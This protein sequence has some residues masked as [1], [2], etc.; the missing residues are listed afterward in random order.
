VDPVTGQP[1]DPDPGPVDPDGEWP[2]IGMTTQRWWTPVTQ[3]LMTGQPANDPAQ[4]SGR[5]DIIIGSDP[6]V[7]L[8]TQTHIDGQ[9]WCWLFIVDDPV[10]Q[11]LWTDDPTVLLLTL[12]WTQLLLLWTDP[13]SVI[14]GRWLVIVWLWWR[15]DEIINYWARILL[16]SPI[17]DYWQLA[18]SIDPVIIGIGVC[19]WRTF[20]IDL[21]GIIID[22]IIGIIIVSGNYWTKTDIVGDYWTDGPNYCDIIVVNP[23]DSD[24][25][26][27]IGII[28]PVGNWKCY[29]HYCE[30]SG[31]LLL[32]QLTVG[33]W[34]LQ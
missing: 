32:T 9:Y 21:I 7:V 15:R 3:L 8:K 23:I 31:Q 17:V 18:S 27:P 22:S 5:T 28:D 33:Q 14:D 10:A 34:Q 25:H 4:P 29:W 20:I 30:P 16:L 2:I 1:S 13:L 12:Y 26:W 19:D 24:G 11:L 6:I